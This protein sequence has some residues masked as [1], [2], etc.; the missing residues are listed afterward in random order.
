MEKTSGNLKLPS[1]DL[2]PKA[3]INGI[4]NTL[5]A[6]MLALQYVKRLITQFFN[7]AE[8]LK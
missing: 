8:E 1:A 3:I 5:N 6:S 4:N 7:E 2:K